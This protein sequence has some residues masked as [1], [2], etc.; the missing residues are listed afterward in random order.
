M[1]DF[2]MFERDSDSGI[3]REHSVTWL[4]TNRSVLHMKVLRCLLMFAVI[5]PVWGMSITSTSFCD[6]V[7]TTSNVLG[8]TSCSGP[9]GDPA[10]GATVSLSLLD[11]GFTF[12]LFTY[13]NVTTGSANAAASVTASLWTP[14]PLR[15]GFAVL[16]CGSSYLSNCFNVT[17]FG[18]GFASVR[19]SFQSVGCQDFG[20]LYA[21]P[22]VIEPVEL[23]QE[24]QFN[25]SVASSAATFGVGEGSADGVTVDFFEDDG[26]TPV[27]VTE[28][29]EPCA[30]SLFE[31]G[32]LALLYRTLSAHIAEST[33][34]DR[35]DNQRF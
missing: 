27:A 9:N 16:S 34:P 12:S 33:P 2:D 14:G 13:A 11:N 19:F 10:A 5:V 3:P 4:E 26:I 24:F 7:Q 18:D 29:P 32:V 21:P 15:P 30:L 31:F 6:P 35:P 25:A 23:G 8:S 28:S 1:Y 17:E 22:A 20:C